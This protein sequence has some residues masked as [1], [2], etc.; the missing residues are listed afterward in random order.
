MCGIKR[1]FCCCHFLYFLL[2]KCCSNIFLLQVTYLCDYPPLLICYSRNRRTHQLFI[3][4]I[5]TFQT[6]IPGVVITIAN[7]SYICY[8]LVSTILLYSPILKGSNTN[9]M[10][11][12]EKTDHSTCMGILR[13]VRDALDILNGKWKLPIIVALSFG[14]KRFGEIAREV[15]GI[16]DRMLSKELRDLEINGL[17]KRTVENS[18]PVK[19]T[20]ALTPHSESLEE[21]IEALK[22]W[23][24]LHRKK[25]LKN[26]SKQ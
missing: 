5:R 24:I 14:E 3:L 9:S 22:N 7:L 12:I 17:V 21:V 19:V 13:P 15:H 20:Y 26:S 4:F 11:K 2:L 6:I 18:Y 16:T 8:T 25:I 1:P 10:K 23:G